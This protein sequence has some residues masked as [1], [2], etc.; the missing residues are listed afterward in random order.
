MDHP[1]ASIYEAGKGEN[2]KQKET[3][4]GTIKATF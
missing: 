1:C 2:H 3:I 4:S